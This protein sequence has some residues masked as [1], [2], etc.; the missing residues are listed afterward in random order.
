MEPTIMPYLTTGGHGAPKERPGG[1]FDSFWCASRAAPC[2][3][4]RVRKMTPKMDPSKIEILG[5]WGFY[6][7][8]LAEC[9]DPGWLLIP[10]NPESDLARVLPYGGGG[11]N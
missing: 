1:D 11:L 4:K 5:L 6:V 2:P 3:K 8:G 9:A 7:L 10:K